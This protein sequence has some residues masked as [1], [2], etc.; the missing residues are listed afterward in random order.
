MAAEKKKRILHVLVAL[1]GALAVFFSA[2]A[3]HWF[4]AIFRA[5]HGTGLEEWTH[6]SV[7][8]FQSTFK[9]GAQYQLIHAVVILV[10]YFA[11]RQKTTRP[12]PTSAKLHSACLA[13]IYLFL[14]STF[15]FSG[16]LYV[17]SLTGQRWL[18]AITPIG[19]L[20]LIIAWL[21]LGR[22]CWRD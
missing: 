19:G 14:V 6:D 1:N 16:S 12:Q 18:G 15:V 17:L 8:S 20:G 21:S 5:L 4:E 13:S 2:F 9:T 22:S 7:L 10:L 11:M 3:A